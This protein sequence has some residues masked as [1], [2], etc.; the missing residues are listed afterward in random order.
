MTLFNVLT[1]FPDFDVVT[2]NF[3]SATSPSLIL[4][5]FEHHCE[6][7]RTTKGI[8]LRPNQVGKWLVIFCDE[9]NLPSI[10]SFDFLKNLIKN[11]FFR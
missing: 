7:K 3:S 10:G 2:L 5:T 9:I 1:S 4:K 8:V 11:F 6:Y